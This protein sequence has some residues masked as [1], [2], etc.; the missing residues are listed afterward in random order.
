MS[1]ENKMPSKEEIVNM[2]KE[3]F[4]DGKHDICVCGNQVIVKK[5]GVDEI[6]NDERR[7]DTRKA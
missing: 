6:G 1:K 3:T 4:D 7:K 5:K 2:I